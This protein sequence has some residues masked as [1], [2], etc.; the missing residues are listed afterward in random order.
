[1]ANMYEV[2]KL[3]DV[4]TVEDFAA[5]VAVLGNSDVFVVKTGDEVDIELLFYKMS[6]LAATKKNVAEIMGNAFGENRVF[7]EEMIVYTIEGQH[8]VNVDEF[9]G[10]MC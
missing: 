4:A 1:M 10:K 5:Y 3:A 7:I 6:V 8:Y 2:V 9:D